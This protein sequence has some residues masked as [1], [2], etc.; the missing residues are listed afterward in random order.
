M[1]NPSP[2]KNSVLTLYSIE[3]QCERTPEAIA[4]QWPVEGFD[5][6]NCLTYGEL[7]RRA[8]QV[9]HFLQARGVGPETLVGLFM[10]RSVELVVGAIGVLKAGG[11]F[12]PLD[13]AIPVDRLTFMLT[14]T[15]AP[16]ILTQE[17]L[18]KQLPDCKAE[19]ICLDTVW[20]VIAQECTIRLISGVRSGNLSS[21]LYTSGS[22]GQPKAVMRT[23]YGLSEQQSRPQVTPLFTPQDRHLLKGSL[24]VVAFNSEL[25]RPLGTGGQMTIVPAGKELDPA[26]LIKLITAYQITVIDL[27]P[28][29]L[30][31]LLD[32]PALESCTS[33]R[34]IICSGEALPVYLQERLFSRLDV[35]L[36]SFYGTTE[37]PGATSSKRQ[38]GDGQP[39]MGD[40]GWPEVG[41]QVYILDPQLQPVP[42]GV[43]GELYLAGGLARGYL[44][45]PDL[46][47][48]RF[49]PNPFSD[50]PGE[51]MYKTG[52][53]GRYLAGGMIELLGRLDDQVQV[54]GFRVEPGEV[55]VALLQHSEISTAVVLA[56][57]IRHEPDQKHLVAYVVPKQEPAPSVS[58]LRR[59]LQ[60]K[61]P[62]YML[63][64]TI[65]MVAALPLLP[66]G[67]LDRQALPVPDITR[68]ELEEMF[69]APRDEL[70][71]QL[72]TIWEQLLGIQSISIKDNFF[73]LGGH[74]LLGVRLFAQIEKIIGKKIP[75]T[76][77]FQAPTIEQL[78]H[79][80]RQEGWS[81]S[82]SS[83][84][85]LRPG[86]KLPFFCLPGN[87]GNV[88]TDL[89]ALARHLGPD[90]P[91]YGLQDNAH[92]PTEIEALA[93]YYVD[94]IRTAQPQG[95]YFL[96]GICSGGIVAFEMARQLQAQGEQVALLALVES[97]PPQTPTLRSNFKF[98]LNIFRRFVRR[99]SHQVSHV[100]SAGLDEWGTFLRLKVKVILNIWA[101]R[102]Y[103]PQPYLGRIQL[104]MARDTIDLAPDSSFGW[105]KLATDGA[106]IHII[107]GNHDAITGDNNTKV[108]EAFMQVLAEQLRVCIDEAITQG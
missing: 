8:N 70:E 43:P 48:E 54:R 6:D 102:R 29:M 103:T 71:L 60:Q 96:G 32:E 22:T 97:S 10:E 72:S 99:F 80:I 101:A 37:S 95:P 81:P 40:I 59:F 61:L 31:L 76:T 46:T 39:L 5:Q 77:L 24:G 47:A 78:A 53:L 104:F 12:I 17:R 86:S 49:V 94:E 18:I 84:V 90:Q 87:L 27:V 57:D 108:N 19:V 30:R 55:E 93:A 2:V 16:I 34:C 107:P 63:P 69:V 41:R 4:V 44:N 64:S 36:R 83:L 20:H 7:D 88:F 52:D 79:V 33:L 14:D 25:F 13:P 91:F 68:P 11:A 92:N 75:L 85:L 42:T 56:R 62:R 3:E 38:R 58:E 45:R 98:G 100:A 105:D 51:R 73:D 28:S 9:A 106:E 74:S 23:H 67:K 21:I 82:T 15:H 35:T 50:S 65:M 1:Q 89:G 26:Y 66:N